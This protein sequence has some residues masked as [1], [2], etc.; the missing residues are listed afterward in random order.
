MTG[1]STDKDILKKERGFFIFFDE[2]GIKNL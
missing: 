2:N 1:T